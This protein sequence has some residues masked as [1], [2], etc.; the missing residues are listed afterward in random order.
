MI[1]IAW[2]VDDVLNELMLQWFLDF[3]KST[4]CNLKFEDLTINP[5]HN[6]LKITKMAYLE[7]LDQYRLSGKYLDLSPNEKIL[8][9]FKK[10]GHL[11]RHIVVTAVPE[12]SAFI[13][14]HWVIKNFGKWIRTFHFVPSERNEERLPVYDRK[15]ID[16][17]KKIKDI[18]IFIEDNEDNV[19]DA[20][21]IG[22]KGLLVKRPWNSSK[23]SLEACL[24]NLT[25]YIKEKDND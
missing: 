19:N 7:S 13:S 22:I 20:N 6:L 18:Q 8:S 10:Y 12:R 9:W 3:K 23:D 2:D 25:K 1:T 15:K 4:T 21:S 16:F 5:P 11:A 24:K 14:A 17:L